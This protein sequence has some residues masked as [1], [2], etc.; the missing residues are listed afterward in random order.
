MGKTDLFI[1]A[2]VEDNC[3]ITCMMWIYSE[4]L[5][6]VKPVCEIRMMGILT[7]IHL[8]RGMKYGYNTNSLEKQQRYILVKQ[9]L[10]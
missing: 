4:I 10:W 5:V 9:L 2:I 8:G 7:H 6:Q 3:S 1:T